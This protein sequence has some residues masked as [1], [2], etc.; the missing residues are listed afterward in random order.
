MIKTNFHLWTFEKD[1]FIRYYLLFK[2]LRCSYNGL[3]ALEACQPYYS[4]QHHSCEEELGRVNKCMTNWLQ[5]HAG[6]PLRLKK[7][8]R[9][10]NVSNSK[11]PSFLYFQGFHYS[12]LIYLT[13][14]PLG[15]SR[16]SK[17]RSSTWHSYNIFPF[18]I[19]YSPAGPRDRKK[20]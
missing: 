15:T 1:S 4:F 12:S 11:S 3:L 18:L 7:K 10:S 20:H 9:R 13:E 19:T 14:P 2:E 8:P 5:F 17:S 16:T 6:D